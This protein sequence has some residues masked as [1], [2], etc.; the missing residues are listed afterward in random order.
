MKHMFTIDKD[1][2]TFKPTK[3]ETKKYAPLPEA[4]YR[5][6]ITEADLV[7][8][9]KGG[10]F[11]LE[12]VVDDESSNFNNRKLWDKS[13]IFARTVS[14]TA[15]TIGT[16]KIGS[17]LATLKLP[18]FTNDE[19]AEATAKKLI[20]ATVL[21]K[22]GQREYQGKTYNEIKGYL[23]LDSKPAATVKKVSV[24]DSDEELPF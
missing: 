14:P 13:Y 8:D 17:L 10:R 21:A 24:K 22:V 19:E 20:G 6:T 12:L 2:I 7:D 4:N 1:Q 9:D 23:P 11:E 15:A 16:K 18:A 3:E 5:L